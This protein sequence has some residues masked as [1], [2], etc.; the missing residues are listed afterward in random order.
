M[1]NAIRRLLSL[2]PSIIRR[3]VEPLVDVL[4][5]IWTAIDNVYH[6]AR[7]RVDGWA[8]SAIRWRSAVWRYLAE[9]AAWAW[10]VINVALPNWA[11]NAINAARRYAEDILRS[12]R[13][14]LLSL[15]DTLRRYA[16]NAVN[17]VA[18]YATRLA[19]WARSE[20]DNIWN[21]LKWVRDK[22]HS[23]LT[24]P[25]L[26]ASWLFCALLNMLIR[27]VLDNVDDLAV[28]A[29]RRRKIIESGTLSIVESI[30]A[31]LL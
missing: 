9:H 18:A 15:V 30:V 29:W 7:S 1:I 5:A 10:H 16:I 6:A 8:Q 13:N 28:A 24:S 27:W 3:W 4:V 25:D 2:A 19:N 17:T 11:T 14:E 31:R 12:V 20:V 26:L 23:L 22:V 21:T